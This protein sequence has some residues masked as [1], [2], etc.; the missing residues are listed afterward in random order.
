MVESDAG[1]IKAK[2]DDQPHGHA[3]ANKNAHDHLPH[4]G[5]ALLQL[6]ADVKADRVIK[7]LAAHPHEKQGQRPAEEG[8]E[9]IE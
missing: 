1:S 2:A 4:G 5:I 3:D 6:V 8:V 7:Y 9:E